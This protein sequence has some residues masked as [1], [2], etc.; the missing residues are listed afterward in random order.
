M[1]RLR[2]IFPVDASEVSVMCV[3]R[4][5]SLARLPRINFSTGHGYVFIK[6]DKRARDVKVRAGRLA[7]SAEDFSAAPATASGRYLQRYRRMGSGLDARRAPSYRSGETP[8]R[9]YTH[10]TRDAMIRA[11]LMASPASASV[12]SPRVSR[13]FAFCRAGRRFRGRQKFEKKSPIARGAISS[14]DTRDVTS[15]SR[16]RPRCGRLRILKMAGA[17]LLGREAVA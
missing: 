14:R 3:Q 13:R 12:L 6:G 1:C 17:E 8:P 9:R 2:D 4:R 5:V 16:P 15:R 11:S 10:T 7:G